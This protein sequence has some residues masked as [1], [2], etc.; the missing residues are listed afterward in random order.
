MSPYF[1]FGGVS[2]HGGMLGLFVLSLVLI[3]KQGKISVPR[4][5]VNYSFVLLLISSYIAFMSVFINGKLASASVSYFINIVFYIFLGAFF[6]CANSNKYDLESQ[7][8]TI[9]NFLII[10]VVF[11]GI[12]ILLEFQFPSFR[13]AVESI[14]QSNNSNIDYL[15]RSNR[16]RGLASGGA[17]NL[18]LLYGFTLVA[19]YYQFLLNKIRIYTFIFSF[20]VAFFSC[21][22]IGRTGLVVAG[23]GIFVISIVSFFDR[24]LSSYKSIVFIALMFFILPVLPIFLS[25]FMTNYMLDYAL[26]FFYRGLDGI[27]NEGTVDVLSAMTTYPNSFIDAL[28]GVGTDSGGFF[29]HTRSDSGYLKM[30]TT[31]GYPLAI[32]LYISIGLIFIR[33]AQGIIK[34]R[35]LLLTFV[36][37]W[38]FSEIK[39]PFV[40]KGYTA[41]LLWFLLAMLIVDRYFK[42][43]LIRK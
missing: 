19:L 17:A 1:I 9:I 32:M 5:I 2:I 3:F 11:N 42:A 37:A 29:T 18:S 14:L 8:N 16:F 15:E 12:V 24:H 13:S 22:L 26:M 28:F 23:A 21:L 35:W 25:Q 39:E 40:F 31:M 6:Y 30:F 10:S 7:I 43:K 20:S 41:R 4:P 36:G 27:K 33:H 34:Y 38:F